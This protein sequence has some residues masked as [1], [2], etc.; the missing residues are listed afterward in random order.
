MFP[1]E[2]PFRCLLK[3]C[4]K[5][6]RYKGDLSKHIKK[7]HPGHSQD[8]TPVPLQE[9]ELI[10]L[11]NQATASTPN[12][13]ASV[14]FKASTAS[15]TSTTSK[16][17]LTTSIASAIPQ[18][19]VV[20]SNN[21]R[22][23]TSASN[24]DGGSENKFFLPLLPRHPVQHD[25]LVASGFSKDLERWHFS[26]EKEGSYRSFVCETCKASFKQKSDCISHIATV[27][28][29]KK[30]KSNYIATVSSPN[31]II[32]QHSAS[33]S[34]NF[35]L[36]RG[37]TSD[38]EGGKKTRLYKCSVPQCKLKVEKY[39]SYPSNEKQRA[40]WLKAFG[41]TECKS[42]AIVCKSHFL[43]SDIVTRN[44]KWGAV[45]TLNLP[46]MY[47]CEILRSEYRVSHSIP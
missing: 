27:H 23:S 5:R 1:G 15:M 37:R 4:L 30:L 2:K 29:G 20:I 10:N 35:C 22:A 28:E 34:N 40:L 13:N 26:K 19:T 44:L 32:D 7:Y 6:F 21:T 12:T 25:E 8:L 11:Q 38:T 31:I 42:R 14:V 18:A 17:Q 47:S 45:P 3:T 43:E 24:S 36:K 41:L 46:Y 33:T 9:D 16:S 39:F